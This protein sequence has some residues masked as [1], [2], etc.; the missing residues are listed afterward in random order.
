LI[1][2]SAFQLVCERVGGQ[3]ILHHT[4]S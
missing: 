1:N 4:N 2:A 3:Q